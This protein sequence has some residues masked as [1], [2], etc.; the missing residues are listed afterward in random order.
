MHPTAPESNLTQS[1][2]ASETNSQAN[3]IENHSIFEFDGIRLCP[4]W[5]LH[6]E[7]ITRCRGILETYAFPIGYDVIN[8]VE[9][10]VTE[11]N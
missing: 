8:R 7:S 11:P 4:H 2:K 3:A 10:I 1:K 5:E 9:Q 6:F